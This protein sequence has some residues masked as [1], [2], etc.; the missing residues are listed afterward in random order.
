MLSEQSTFVKRCRCGLFF[1]VNFCFLQWFNVCQYTYSTK[2]RGI[3]NYV[4]I[5]KRPI[6]I[7]KNTNLL[8]TQLEQMSETRRCLVYLKITVA[9]SDEKPVSTNGMKPFMK[10][11]PTN[12]VQTGN[13]TSVTLQKEC[14]ASLYSNNKGTSHTSYNA[15]R[16]F[17][18][19]G[20]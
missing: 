8:T 10:N 3:R 14:P 17:A 12:K 13:I 19:I 11:Y 6:F 20:C 5:Q 15:N 7:L 2:G 16:L 1:W 4:L 9:F 18:I